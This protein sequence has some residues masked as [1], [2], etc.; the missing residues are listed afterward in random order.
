M[1]VYITHLFGILKRHQV[2]S[3]IILVKVPT[4]L[5]IPRPYIQNTQDFKPKA[6]YTDISVTEHPLPHG[7]VK[8]MSCLIFSFLSQE[9][10][11]TGQSPSANNPIKDDVRLPNCVY[12]SSIQKILACLKNYKNTL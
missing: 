7:L 12:S 11:E 8:H 6:S 5:L 1:L 2:K 10:R 3:C 9:N 4:S